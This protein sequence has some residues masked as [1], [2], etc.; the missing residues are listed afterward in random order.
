MPKQSREQIIADLDARQIPYSED[1]GYNE[2]VELAKTSPTS[3]MEP[4]KVA[5]PQPEEP[6]DYSNIR[7]GLSTI[8][9]LHRRI[10]L[11][12]RKANA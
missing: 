9:D 2:L 10:T 1:M 4:R 3:P 12:E 8:Q 11:L 5:P 7:C 6:I